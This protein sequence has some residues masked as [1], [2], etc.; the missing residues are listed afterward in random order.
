M[1]VCGVCGK[2]MNA[3]PERGRRTYR[4]SSRDTASGACGSARVPGDDVETWVWDE[5][6]TILRDPETVAAELR[7]RREAGVDS[8]LAADLDA[9]RRALA[10]LETQGERLIRRFREAD[11]D[12]FPWDL[13]Q[14]EI[15]HVEA[16]K[17]Q[18]QA[19]VV[20]LEQ[21]IAQQD[22]ALNQLDALMTYCAT[23]AR[24]LEW[25]GFAE[26]RIA[27]EA[28]AVRVLGNGRDWRLHG[29]IP[30]GDPAGVVAQSSCSQ[31][32]RARAR[33]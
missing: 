17:K 14:R 10:K 11:D 26:K 8:T 33:R 23:A 9:A 3:N 30:V 5:I 2:R 15:A 22:A 4:C 21:Q 29:S 24:N 1:I 12:N 32:R 25:F 20:E 6:A 31:G 7:R 16:E 18:L 19:A 28:L 27:L 13:V